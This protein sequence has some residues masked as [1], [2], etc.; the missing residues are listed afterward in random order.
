MNTIQRDWADFHQY[1]DDSEGRRPGTFGRVSK[2]GEWCPLASERIKIIPRS[3]W[4][5]R[6][7]APSYTGLRPSVPVILDQDGVGSCATED[8][9]Q[10]IMTDGSFNGR[11][12]VQL[13]PWFIYQET[14]GG[15]DGGSSIDENL[16][17]VRKYG[18]APERVWP[19][20]N[21][22]RK[23]PSEEAYEAAKEFKILEFFDI[24]NTEELG[25]ALLLGYP[26][27]Y[28]RRGHAIMATELIGDNEIEYVNSWGNWGDEGFGRDKLSGVNFNYGAW[29][30]RVAT[31]TGE[32]PIV[33]ASEMPP[34]FEPYP[35]IA[36]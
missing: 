16:R 19:R 5:D 1:W 26:V 28:G 29:A 11:E 35:T 15:R 21:G 31:D 24:R 30:I 23:K 7:A 8:T 14:S 32:S 27:A 18:C 2:P 25:S 17:F 10:M 4:R 33:R 6:I 12:F 3:E 34:M 13:N 20:S 9:A 22:W 36:N